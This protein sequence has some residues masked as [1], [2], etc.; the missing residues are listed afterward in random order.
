MSVTYTKPAVKRLT[1][2]YTKLLTL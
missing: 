2:V 1:G